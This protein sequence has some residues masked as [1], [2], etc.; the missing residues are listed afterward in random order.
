MHI[1]PTRRACVALALLAFSGCSRPDG[2]TRF[3]V[4]GKLTLNGKPCPLG[5]LVFAPNTSKGGS[6]PGAFAK[7]EHGVYKTTPGRGVT[8]GPHTVEIAAFD[9]IPNTSSLEGNPLTTKVYTAEIEIPARD[10]EL[11]FDVPAK[12]LVK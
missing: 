1:R 5:T 12:F 8:A 4:S 6:G 9:G 7:G 11:D 2:P 10:C 3:N